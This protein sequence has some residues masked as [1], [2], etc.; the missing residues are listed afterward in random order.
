MDINSDYINRIYMGT[1]S[2]EEG[3][4]KWAVTYLEMLIRNG[5]RQLAYWIWS[6]W[7]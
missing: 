1:I 5:K 6:G 2:S 7:L 3:F 4:C